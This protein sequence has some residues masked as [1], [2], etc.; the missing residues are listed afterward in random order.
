MLKIEELVLDGHH[1]D[2]SVE[3]PSVY[4]ASDET[5]DDW[6]DISF[7]DNNSSLLIVLVVVGC[8][9]VAKYIV[10]A[11]GKSIEEISAEINKLGRR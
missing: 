2:N 7:A 4:F 11:S 9:T 10:N 5:D 6:F 1:I 8:E 3:G